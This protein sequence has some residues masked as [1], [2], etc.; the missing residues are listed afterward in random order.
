MRK[1]AAIL[2]VLLMVMVTAAGCVEEP[3]EEMSIK[4]VVP[5]GITA[6]GAAK[7]IRDNPE[8]AD[9]VTVEYEIAKTPDVLASMIMSEDPGIAVVPSTLAAAA[10]NRGISYQLVGTMGWGSFYL[11]TTEDINAW[12]DLKGEEIYNIGRGMT[13]DIVFRYLLEANDIDAEE[14]VELT[15]LAAATELAPTFIGGTSTVAV[16]PEPM[17]TTVMANVEEAEIVLDLNEEWKNLTDSNLGFPQS[18]LIVKN[19]LL[20]EHRPVVEAFVE[21]FADSVEWAKENPD[22]LVEYASDL[23]IGVPPIAI[24]ESMARANQEYIAVRDSM[25]EY[26]IYYNAMFE[27][28]P[29]VIGGKLPDEGLYDQ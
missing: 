27:Y 29:E 15:Y 5:D 26:E 24:E 11:L 18:S 10:Y 21:Y 23:E 25:S 20:E 8:L 4:I 9:Y 16:M 14:D 2:V 17:L 19:E 12:E 3:K 13:P 22:S 7:V 28:D 6:L 1:V